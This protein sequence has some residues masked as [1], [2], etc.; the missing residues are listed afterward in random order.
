MLELMLGQIA[1]ISR[2]AIVK[3]STSI[4]HIWQ[5]IR[6]L[7][8]FQATG[9]HFLDFSDIKL[10]VD[11]RPEDLYQRLVA[12][13]EDNLL[14]AGGE[15]TH[16]GAAPTEDEDILQSELDRMHTKSKL[17]YMSTPAA[18]CSFVAN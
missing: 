1:K 8:G 10:E 3:A 16:H 12:F 4:K 18:S 11:E 5:A 7:F 13:T 2:N 6:N 17:R 9:A 15:I 14:R